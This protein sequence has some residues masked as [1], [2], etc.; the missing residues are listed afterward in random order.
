MSWVE[1]FSDPMI[2]IVGG[3]EVAVG[4]GLIL[5]W[6][7]DVAPILTPLSALGVIAIL[8]EV[9]LI[10]RRRGETQMLIGNSMLALTA[11]IIA[12]GRFADL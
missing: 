8:A 10:H 1:D 3:L 7:F 11:A 2:R 9:M 6:A 4:L 12:L 5:P